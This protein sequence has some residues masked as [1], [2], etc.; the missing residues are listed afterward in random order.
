[1]PESRTPP[2]R[3]IVAILAADVAGYSRLMGRD[4]EGTYAALRG[5]LDELFIPRI[6]AFEGRIIKFIGDGLLAE[7]PSAVDALN[8]AAQLQ[9]EMAGRNRDVPKDRQLNFRIGLHVGDVMEVDGDLFGDGVNTAARVEGTATPG[10]INVSRFVYD[11]VRKKVPLEFEDL[12]EHLFKSFEEAVTVYRVTGFLRAGTELRL[13]EARERIA[14]GT[15]LN[16]IYEVDQLLAIGS[17]SEVYRAR[18]VQTGDPVVIKALSP[19]LVHSPEAIAKVRAQASALYKL[20][21]DAVAHTFL[22]SVDEA[23]GQPYLAMETVDGISLADRVRHTPLSLEEA[24]VLRQRLATALA[25]AHAAGVVHRALSPEAIVLPEGDVARSTLIDFEITGL[26]PDSERTVITST[27]ETRNLFQSPEQIGHFGAKEGPETDVYSLG[28][29]LAFAVT[30]KP[31][32][33]PGSYAQFVDDRRK[34][35]DLSAVPGTMRPLLRAMLEPDPKERLSDMKAVAEGSV[36]AKA[37]GD[38]ERQR[39]GGETRPRRKRAGALVAAAL[40]AAALAGG[41]VWYVTLHAPSQGTAPGK[42]EVAA[43]VR[44]AGEAEAEPGPPRLSAHTDPPPAAPVQETE[45]SGEGVPR[46]GA[47]GAEGASAP[48][49]PAQDDA[50]AASALPSV[51]ESAPSSPFGDAFQLAVMD[52]RERLPDAI[53]SISAVVDRVN[54]GPCFFASVAEVGTGSLYVDMYAP[55][56][57]LIYNAYNELKASLEF[58]PNVTGRLI[59][60]GQCIALDFAQLGSSTSTMALEI[61]PRALSAGDPLDGAIANVPQESVLLLAIDPNGT[62]YD[63]SNALEPSPAGLRF[64]LNV[65]FPETGTITNLMLAVSIP[66]GVEVPALSPGDKARDYLPSLARVLSEANA[67]VA[68]RLNHFVLRS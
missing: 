6:E 19:Q 42:A 14:P 43:V 2:R 59:S 40:V 61:D 10:G 58:D 56:A 47:E 65:N 51:T 44:D 34:P 62:L 52:G 4:E 38:G 37:R 33:G 31:L 49:E 22:F 15:R 17:T 12:G 41:G 18:S 25:G 21:H 39:R 7:F 29:V 5:H 53:A 68:I 54:E 67:P 57:E 1:M 30:G 20:Q 13:G 50:T 48:R 26:R 35:H 46:D 3:K 24:A 60:G 55:D 11:S 64:L 23:L 16:G 27:V 9:T 66:G 45:P 8:C 28:L 32:D 63:L 36:P